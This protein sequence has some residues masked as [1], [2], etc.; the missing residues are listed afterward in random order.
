MTISSR[1]PAAGP[2]VLTVPA[3]GAAAFTVPGPAAPAVPAGGADVASA[4]PG[5]PVPGSLWQHYKGG[6]YRIREIAVDEASGEPVVV[7]R[8]VDPAAPDHAWLRP[9]A[10]FTEPVAGLDGRT[11]ARFVPIREPGPQPMERVLR[12]A[13]GLAPGAV[14]SILARYDEAGRYYHARWH[15]HDLFERAV[16]LGHLPTHAQTLALLAHDAVYVPGATAGIN[17]RLSALLLRQLAPPAIA[18]DVAAACAIIEDTAGHRAS[19][20]DAS[21]VCALDLASLGDDADHFDA[22]SEMVRLEYRHLLPDDDRRAFERA[23]VQ[24][25]APLAAVCRDLPMP[26]GFH[27]AFEANLER[28]RRRGG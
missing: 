22:R 2:A 3:A 1:P 10:R 15:V 6:L 21:L 17:E 8:P 25:L 13:C 4:V 9:L 5:S 27:A 26:A 20:A 11:R 16:D 23:R 19:S 14:T 24:A 12:D 28:W 7:Y 18:A